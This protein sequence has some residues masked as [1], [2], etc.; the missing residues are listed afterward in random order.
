ME[1]NKA[2]SPYLRKNICVNCETEF[3]GFPD[4]LA[5]SIRCALEA[6]HIDHCPTCENHGSIPMGNDPN[7]TNYEACPEGCSE[8]DAWVGEN[9]YI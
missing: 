3:I 8:Y 1:N 5:C 7:P 2:P 4:E 6:G 9:Y